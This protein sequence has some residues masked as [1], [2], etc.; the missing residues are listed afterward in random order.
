MPRRKLKRLALMQTL[1]ILSIDIERFNAEKEFR[2]RYERGLSRKLYERGAD[3]DTIRF[4]V[5]QCVSP[6]PDFGDYYLIGKAAY[7]G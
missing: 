6:G 7:R 3:Y 5:K 2:A 4:E 1:L